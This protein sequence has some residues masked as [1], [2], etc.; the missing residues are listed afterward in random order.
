VLVRF[1]S[2]FR[3]AR[4]SFNRTTV[5]GSLFSIITSVSY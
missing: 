1:A 3:V 2:A 4:R 5:I